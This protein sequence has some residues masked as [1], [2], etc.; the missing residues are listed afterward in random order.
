MDIEQLDKDVQ[1]ARGIP[2][3]TNHGVCPSCLKYEPLK[4]MYCKSCDSKLN[5]DHFGEGK[6]Q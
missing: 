4:F 3:D 5:L 2:A 6:K 1:A